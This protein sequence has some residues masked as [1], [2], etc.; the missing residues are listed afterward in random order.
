MIQTYS[1]VRNHRG[2]Q[3]DEWDRIVESGLSWPDAQR[4]ESALTK[5][6]VAAHP[7]QTCWTR[8]LFWILSEG[9]DRHKD[10]LAKLAQG[11]LFS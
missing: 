4:R 7:E 6:E 2:K 5:A 9:S 8:D 3:G 10:L 11:K 1:V